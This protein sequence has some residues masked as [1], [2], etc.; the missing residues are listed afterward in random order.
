MLAGV[1]HFAE[2][3]MCAAGKRQI[4]FALGCAILLG[5]FPY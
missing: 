2:G 1:T 4:I 3:N 5:R